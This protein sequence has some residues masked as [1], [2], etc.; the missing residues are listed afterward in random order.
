MTEK[1]RDPE[2]IPQER[3]QPSGGEGKVVPKRASPALKSSSAD[4]GLKE[5]EE[6]HLEMQQ[7][8]VEGFLQAS[9]TRRTDKKG[10]YTFKQT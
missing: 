10:I 6:R 9:C 3:A 5:P 8:A 7:T 2:Q 4:K 1:H